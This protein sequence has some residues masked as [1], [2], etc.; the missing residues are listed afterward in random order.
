LQE[1]TSPHPAYL[2]Q[3]AP[4]KWKSASCATDKDGK[5]LVQVQLTDKSGE[6]MKQLAALGF[7][8]IAD[9]RTTAT[10]AIGRD[11]ALKL[12]N[13]AKS[14]RCVMPRSSTHLRAAHR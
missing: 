12:D 8:V 2:A 5:V 14:R 11:P 1:L 9:S 4:E 10:V 7:E 13:L 6:T 3:A